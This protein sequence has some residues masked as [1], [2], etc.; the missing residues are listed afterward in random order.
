MAQSG[1]ANRWYLLYGALLVAVPVAFVLAARKL[2]W[3][4]HR[5]DS[6]TTYRHFGDNPLQL[7]QFDAAS[8]MDGPGPAILLFHGGGWS[9]GSPR[10]FYPQCE[11]FARHGFSCFS[12]AYRLG[13]ATAPD[14]RGAVADAA[15][16]LDYLVENA[17]RF[18]IDPE[19]LYVGG[20][21]AGGHLAASLGAGLHGA[22]RRR[23]TG[24][25]LYNPVIDLSPCQPNHHLVR[26]YWQEISPAQHIDQDFPPTLILSGTEDLEVL[27]ASIETFCAGVERAGGR[28]DV[29]VY[30]NQAH[31]FFNY[32]E[33]GNPYFGKTNER[34]LLFL[35][36]QLALARSAH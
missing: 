14:L 34:A 27:P 18:N 32:R 11:Y 25:V 36:E 7:H 23:P 2:D 24:L 35:Q 13:P 17:D 22:Q 33:A 21:S 12:A 5:A 8:L 16:A 19:R 20:G 10:Q 26:E 3:D 6:Y 29:E 30:A 31:G 1:N 28:C 15:S 4:E 9:H